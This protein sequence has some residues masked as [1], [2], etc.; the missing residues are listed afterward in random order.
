[1]NFS[2]KYSKFER[3]R[4]VVSCYYYGFDLKKVNRM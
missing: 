3:V 1:M 2:R 4:N